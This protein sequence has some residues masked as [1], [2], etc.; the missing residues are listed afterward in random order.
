MLP[1]LLP[2]SDVA[3]ACVGVSA[4][5]P[6]SHLR[7]ACLLSRSFLSVLNVRGLFVGF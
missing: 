2:R 7:I 1:L 4:L 6:A 3:A 5:P